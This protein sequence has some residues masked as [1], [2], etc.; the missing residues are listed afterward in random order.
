MTDLLYLGVLVAFFAATYGLLRMCA[1][2]FHDHQGGR[3]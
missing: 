3:P 1:W 2:L